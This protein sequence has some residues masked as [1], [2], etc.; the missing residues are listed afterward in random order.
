MVSESIDHLG[1]HLFTITDIRDI[2]V[3]IERNGEETYRQAS[4]EA[5]DPEI[6]T[7][8]SWMADEE[9]RH[10]QWFE[11]IKSDKPLTQEQL[12]LEKM[13]R[14]LLQE[15][16]ADQTF[17][18]EQSEL[19]TV[20]TFGEL[21]AQ[22]KAFEKDTILFY[23]FLK[24]IIEEDDVRKQLDIIIKEEQKHFERLEELEKAGND[25]TAAA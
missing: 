15:M 11:N 17:S 25:S 22:S 9:K 21:I 4:R 1:A 16:V 5:T 13:G 24:G 14:K 20:T 8:F 2:A 10:A 12:E 19:K 6:G 3:Q 18:L 7:L 23:E